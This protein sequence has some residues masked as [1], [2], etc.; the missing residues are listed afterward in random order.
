[1][2]TLRWQP[3]SGIAG[4]S[5]AYLRRSARLPLANRCVN[6]VSSPRSTSSA[7]PHPRWLA[8]LSVPSPPRL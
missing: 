7:S 8:I 1:M 4:L 6:S 2:V 3:D 5:A